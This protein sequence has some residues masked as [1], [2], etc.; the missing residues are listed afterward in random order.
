MAWQKATDGIGAF[1]SWSA[2]ACAAASPAPKGP[3]SGSV[4]TVSCRSLTGPSPAS[5]FSL[6]GQTWVANR[7][8]LNGRVW[9][10]PHPG[11]G[12]RSGPGIT[13]DHVS[14]W[15][16]SRRA[17][18]RTRPTASAIGGHTLGASNPTATTTTK[19][20]TDDKK[21]NATITTP[22]IKKFWSCYN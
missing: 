4:G 16:S 17:V 11:P 7:D 10:K 20:S 6:P 3:T 5:T 19:T 14:V 21:Y 13:Y 22:T 8:E 1:L 2:A 15:G 12:V 18:A 9:D